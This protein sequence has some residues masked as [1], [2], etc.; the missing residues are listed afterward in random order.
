MKI[1][2][3]CLSGS[4][5]RFDCQAKTRTEIQAMVQRGEALPVCPEQLGGL[6]TPR[7]PAERVGEQVLT[8][9]GKDVTSEFLRGAEEALQIAKLC[10]ATE[11]FL[12][13]KSPM[14]GSNRIYDGSFSGNVIA[15]D[16]VFAA[17]LKKNGIK[18]TEVD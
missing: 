17:L 6:S 1:V 2:S 4:H 14:C 16:G 18:V 15:G 9:Q 12:K 8:K 3:A 7:P 11:A 13:S 10:G 5:C